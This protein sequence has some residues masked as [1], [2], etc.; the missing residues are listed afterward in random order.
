MISDANSTAKQYINNN[1][2]SKKKS[3]TEDISATAA[4]QAKLVLLTLAFPRLRIIWSS[5]PYATAEIFNDL[6]L[7]NAE[8]DPAKAITVGAEEDSNAG[9]G[10]NTAAEELLRTFPGITAKN[11]KYVMSKVQNVREL[12]EMDLAGIQNILGNEPGKA[13][14]NFLHRGDRK[15]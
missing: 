7:H 15:V 1:S 3:I 12:C 10:V 2:T 6:K 13:C 8:P 14:Y 9:A 5:S 11:V 4:I